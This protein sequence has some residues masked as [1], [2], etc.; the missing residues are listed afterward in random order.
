MYD[1]VRMMEDVGLLP[2]PG[3]PPVICSDK[4]WRSMAAEAELDFPDVMKWY[5]D[6]RT[7]DFQ[8]AKCK[9]RVIQFRV[10]EIMQAY[11]RK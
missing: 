2:M 10:D 3:K 5:A 4:E 6:E 11:K 8:V 1:I 7:I 9:R